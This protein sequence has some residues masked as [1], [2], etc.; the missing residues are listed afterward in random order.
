MKKIFF[1]P[2]TAVDFEL[3]ARLVRSGKTDEQI[4]QM[5]TS[6]EWRSMVTIKDEEPYCDSCL[7]LIDLDSC[8]ECGQTKHKR[9]DTSDAFYAFA[10]IIITTQ[11]TVATSVPTILEKC[12]E[13]LGG[14]LG[15]EECLA[16]SNDA[17]RAYLQ[18]KKGQ[19]KA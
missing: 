2:R 17:A 5:F 19:Q 1:G 14:V 10:C 18:M 4:E 8:E 3:I 15:K 13:A 16:I 7:K 12:S 11:L 9:R 6:S